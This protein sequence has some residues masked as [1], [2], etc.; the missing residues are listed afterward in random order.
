MRG[1]LFQLI[2]DARNT[3]REHVTRVGAPFDQASSVEQSFAGSCLV[4]EVGLTSDDVC[5]EPRPGQEKPADDGCVISGLG[6][7]LDPHL[8]KRGGRRGWRRGRAGQWY[9]GCAAARS[10]LTERKCSA[11]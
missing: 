4:R 2:G 6:T 3:P 7:A 9:L 5:G 10:R 1:A 11:R 8:D